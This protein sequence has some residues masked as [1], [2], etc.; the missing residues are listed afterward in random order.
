MGGR[1]SGAT[2]TEASGADTPHPDLLRWRSQSSLRR[3]RR[4]VCAIDLPHRGVY[5]RAAL[6]AGPS[7]GEGK[8]IAAAVMPIVVIRCT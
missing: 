2:H 3:L 1:T 6:C 5:H 4:L 8:E 7:A